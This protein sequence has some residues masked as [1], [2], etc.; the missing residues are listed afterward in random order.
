MSK[1]FDS[2]MRSIGILRFI[3][4]SELHEKTAAAFAAAADYV[5][6]TDAVL[7]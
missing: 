5:N 1:T 2:F 3:N 4:E 7:I 6:V